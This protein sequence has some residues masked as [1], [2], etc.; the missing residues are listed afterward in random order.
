MP[1]VTQGARAEADVPRAAQLGRPAILLSP[2]CRPVSGEGIFWGH[3][4][5]VVEKP[6]SVY[7]APPPPFCLYNLPFIC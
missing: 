2:A 4:T 7:P 1:F 3:K 6:G 5:R